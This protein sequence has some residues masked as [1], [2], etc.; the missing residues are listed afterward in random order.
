MSRYA[1]VDKVFLQVRDHDSYDDSYVPPSFDRLGRFADHDKEIYSVE[2]RVI[3]LKRTLTERFQMI[4]QEFFTLA[5]FAI[6]F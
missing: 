2:D 3:I 6:F 1:L 4:K 5:F